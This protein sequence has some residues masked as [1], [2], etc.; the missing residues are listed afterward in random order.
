M[1]STARH[2]TGRAPSSQLGDVGIERAEEF[3][4]VHPGLV[5]FGRVGFL[6]K[7]LVYGLTGVLA[8]AIGVEAAQGS[9]TT[10]DNEAS[11]SGAIARI[12]E[13]SFGTTVLI[14]VAAGLI[15]YSLWRIVSVILPAGNDVKAW[16]T[17]AG[18][19]VSA[20][21]YL[22]LASTAI[23][24]VRQPGASGDSED[25][26]VENFTRD[27]MDRSFGRA[28]VI[29]VGALLIAIAAAFVWKAVSASFTGQMLP[30]AVGPVSQRTIVVLGRIGWAGRAAMMALIGFFLISAAVTFEPQDAQG[31]DGSLRNAT[32]SGPGTALVIAVGAGL[33][34][35]GVFCAISAPKQRLV[36]ADT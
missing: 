12:A 32:S 19:L 11:Q 17:R 33:L 25:N 7:G 36:G 24:V 26:K 21:T 13:N 5:R 27:L 23:A 29:M 34:V 15:V 8:L 3:A 9:T 14:V 35:F 30:G 31:L 1:S 4:R 20:V 18:Y 28:A 6:A 16:F 22:A 2:T 10:G